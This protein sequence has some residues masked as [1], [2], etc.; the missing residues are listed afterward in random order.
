MSSHIS[1]TDLTCEVCGRMP[2]PR[3]A[4]MTAATVLAMLPVELAVHA[5]ILRSGLS[6]PFKVLVLTVTATALAIWVAE[7]SVMRM[8]RRWLHG[9]VLRTRERY[10]GAESLWRIRTKVEDRPGALGDVTHALATLGGNILDVHVHPAPG[11]PV[12]EFVV[13]TPA[14]VTPRALADAV[15]DAD[16]EDPQIWPTTPLALVDGQTKALDLAV[17]VAAD[18]HVL[19]DALAEL[20]DAE[21]AS[22]SPGAPASHLTAGATALKV[23]ATWHG[24]HAFA[25]P[26]RPFTL[27]ESARA[28]RLAELAEVVERT[29]TAQR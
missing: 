21:P 22:G 2:E 25:R 20:L 4:R 10:A 12:D 5:L 3:K 6:L 13:S 15:R 29:R 28:H 19:P 14:G 24:A 11:G 18:P 23:P 9:P 1:P 17:Q 27:A 7:P 16:G 26:G 8:L